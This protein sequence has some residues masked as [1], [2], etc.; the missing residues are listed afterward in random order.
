MPSLLPDNIEEAWQRLATIPTFRSL[1]HPNYRLFFFG[2]IFSLIGTWMQ[3]IAM[4]WLVYQLTFSSVWL[5]TIGF[6]TSVPS[7]FLSIFAGTLADRMSKRKLI[8]IMQTAA[9]VQALLLGVLVFTNL[10]TIYVA[11][12][13]A[14]TLGVINSFDI[15]SRQ[16]FIVDLV[17]KEDIANAIGLNSATFNGARIVGPAIGGLVIGLIGVGWCFTLNAVSFI[18]VL[19]GLFKM[20]VVEPP[21]ASEQ[22]SSVVEALRESVAY[23]RSDPSLTALMILVGVV[24]TFGW[25][26]SV[27][28]PIFAD[29]ELQIGAVGL[30]RLYMATGIGAF[31]SAMTI[32]SAG[33]RIPPRKFIYMGIAIFSCSIIGFGLST[34]PSF[35]MLC[36][37]GVG[38]GLIACFATANA[39]LQG[40]APDALRGRVMGLYS[41]VFQGMMPIGSLISGIVAKGIG[42]RSTVIIGGL[43]S[44]MTAIVVF[45]VRQ[46]QRHTAS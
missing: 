35:S 15:P 41:L 10:V 39:T 26:Y 20:T 25:S 28:L 18:A 9:L 6:L 16:S 19:I 3:S 11:A 34:N 32:A 38:M 5:G 17:G 24:T 33:G 44:G 29:K 4:S 40:R 7:L 30:G 43:I 2:Q 36:L 23:I 1:R 42:V 22:R 46:K 13:F 14:L 45:T 8:I 21:P 27:L 37:V 31:I 12:F